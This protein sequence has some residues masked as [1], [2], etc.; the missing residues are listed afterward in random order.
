MT[1]AK[2]KVDVTS[3]GDNSK[4]PQCR[5]CSVVKCSKGV[6]ESGGGILERDG[7]HKR[8]KPSLKKQLRKTQSSPADS[9]EKTVH[10]S[11]EWKNRCG[12]KFPDAMNDTRLIVKVQK[13]RVN[14]H[15]V[16]EHRDATI[17]QQRSAKVFLQLVNLF[18]SLLKLRQV[19]L[20]FVIKLLESVKPL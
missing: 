9:L 16:Q 12:E 13:D 4:S 8:S 1:Q 3:E 6:F 14:V 20:E 17:P 10:L 5:Q 7:C 15:F 2:V 18:A 11:F 19:L